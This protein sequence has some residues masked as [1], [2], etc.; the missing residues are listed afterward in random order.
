MFFIDYKDEL[1]FCVHFLFSVNEPIYSV[2][3]NLFKSKNI[4]AII[5]VG[6]LKL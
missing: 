4:L 3:V 1:I 2:N 6:L 5:K